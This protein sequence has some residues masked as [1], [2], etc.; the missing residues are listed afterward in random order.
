MAGGEASL[1]MGALV[2]WPWSGERERRGE[3]EE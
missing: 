1:E 2:V 3:I